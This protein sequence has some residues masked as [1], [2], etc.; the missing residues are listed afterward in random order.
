[1][2]TKNSKKVRVIKSTLDNEINKRDISFDN[3]PNKEYYDRVDRNDQQED[4]WQVW[5]YH[6]EQHH[7]DYNF[8]L[9]EIMYR[10]EKACR[11]FY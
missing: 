5:G 1:M 3:H 7:E 2:M 4:I 6:L 10:F 8:E 9:L 11:F